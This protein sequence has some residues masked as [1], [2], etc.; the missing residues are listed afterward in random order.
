[1]CFK[2][3]HI[4]INHNYYLDSNRFFHSKQRELVV[5]EKMSV[6]LIKK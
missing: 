4:Y 2:K 1:M 6:T 5:R 3:A